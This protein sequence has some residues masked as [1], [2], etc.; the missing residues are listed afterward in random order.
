[1]I[2]EWIKRWKWVKDHPDGPNQGA[3][4]LGEDP[5]LNKYYRDWYI[6]RYLPEM[7]DYRAFLNKNP[8]C[9]RPEFW[10]WFLK[11]YIRQNRYP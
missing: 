4:Y 10:D 8:S 7:Q 5:F 1:M 2:G 11:V 3:Q 9:R 6:N